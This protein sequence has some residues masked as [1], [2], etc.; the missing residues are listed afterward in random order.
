MI[1]QVILKPSYE[2]NSF[3]QYESSSDIETYES[4]GTASLGVNIADLHTG[5]ARKDISRYAG[6]YFAERTSNKERTEKIFAPVPCKEALPS[7]SEQFWQDLEAS[8][9]IP[10]ENLM[11]PDT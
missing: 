4:N 1:G 10:S 6:L 3:A 9:E 7:A 8:T 2:V 11:C 5:L